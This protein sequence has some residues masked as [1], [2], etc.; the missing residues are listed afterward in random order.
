MQ[1][2]WFQLGAKTYTVC[3]KG[4]QAF[5]DSGASLIHGPSKEVKALNKLLGATYSNGA[6]TISCDSVNNLPL[7]YFQMAGA[8]FPLRPTAYLYKNGGICYTSFV[9]WSSSL[10]LL[11]DAFMRS[12]YTIFDGANNRIGFASAA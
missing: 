9:G 10:W 8:S 5:V 2:V 4:C 11:G 3:S 6:Y 7:I 12:Y 1:N